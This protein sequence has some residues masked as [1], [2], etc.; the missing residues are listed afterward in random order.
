ML[1]TQQVADYGNSL[2]GGFSAPPK[3]VNQKPKFKDPYGKSQQ[4]YMP[5]NIMIDKRVV[6]GST[7]AAMVIPAGTYP[8]ALFN[9][10]GKQRTTKR[11]T[12]QMKPSADEFFNRD[13]K[14][15]EALAGRQNIDIQTD[16]FVEELTDK[17]P[18]YEIG[19]QTDFLIDRPPSPRSIPIKRGCDAKTLVEDNE[20]FIFDKD[21]EPILSVLCGKTLELARMEV[22]EE[23]ELR[24]MREQQKHF[25][26]VRTA[27]HLEAQRMEKSELQKKQEFERRKQNEREKKKNKIAA[28]RKI[29]SRQIAKQFSHSMKDHAYRHLADVG[30]FTNRFQVNVLEQNVFPWL[31]KKTAKFV[32]ALETLGKF[33]DELMM[34]YFDESEEQHKITVEQEKQRRE[35][36]RLEI[37]N[38][39]RE[40]QEEKEKRKAAREAQR[41]A[42]ELK[43]LKDEIYES[44]IQKGEQK[45]HI[46]QQDLIEVT[47]H[48]IKQTVVGGLG[49]MLGQMILCFSAIHKK[50]KKEQEFLNPKVVQNF[51]FLYIDAKMRAE[52][53]FLQVGK[54]VEDFLA[55]LEKPLQLNEMRV[56]KDANYQRFRQILSD[57]TLYG[58][59]ILQILKEQSK[60]L[61]ISA[62]AYDMVY[63]GL[64]DIYCKKSQSPDLNP[65]KLEGFLQRIKLLTP[66][67]DLVDEEGNVTPSACNLPL[68]AI[69]R[70]RIPL[71]RP[72]KE[73]II[74]ENNE[75]QDDEDNN[76]QSAKDLTSS[77]Q[78]L[79]QSPPLSDRNVQYEEMEIEDKVLAVNPV[80]E[81]S[82]IYIIHQAAQRLF[83]KDIVQQMKKNI[84]ELENIDIEDLISQVETHAVEVENN[85]LRLFGE[86][87]EDETQ[88]TPVF[89]FEIN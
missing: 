40:K 36:V 18:Q 20:L 31:T 86:A 50:W 5:Q 64:W 60:T 9:G 75:N 30:F 22:L 42:N 76:N 17:A 45:E 10:T 33:P 37:E 70:I 54:T 25:D 69:V 32:L 61:G 80:G 4:E 52:K 71:K 41:K 8:D 29:V 58:D 13:I 82:R 65:K 14:T 27:E 46:L 59:E 55:S 19:S 47:G 48:N 23:E 84:K 57:T 67:Q 88:R 38:Q 63:E 89:D 56:M 72:V 15:P 1:S 34:S 83:R 87:K 62:K 21:V 12:N 66:P 11:T 68:K 24:V 73:P 44:F 77:K 74:D 3:V 85:F 16:Q 39:E 2:S 35:N 51:I 7:H 78:N 28:H 43:K 79:P 26:D 53:L 6:R 81:N 49:G